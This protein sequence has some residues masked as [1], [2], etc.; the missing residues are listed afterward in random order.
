MIQAICSGCISQDLTPE[1][2]GTVAENSE[3]HS[4]LGSPT[5]IFKLNLGGGGGGVASVSGQCKKLPQLLD[6]AKSI[7]I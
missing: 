5:Y 4:M 3:R 6:N 2:K 7:K 1:I